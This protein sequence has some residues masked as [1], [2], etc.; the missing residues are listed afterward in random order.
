MAQQS[1]VVRLLIIVKFDLRLLIF[2]NQLCNSI[3]TS[4]ASGTCRCRLLYGLNSRCARLNRFLDFSCRHS[5]AVTYCFVHI[6]NFHLASNDNFNI[7]LRCI[8]KIQIICVCILSFLIY[9]LHFYNFIL[10][11]HFITCNLYFTF[12]IQFIIC[13]IQYIC[14]C[15]LYW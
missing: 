4:T 10:F 15:S 6:H 8:H 11:F 3:N 7:H 9:F 2:L 13:V 5:H 1:Y 12:C 14:Y